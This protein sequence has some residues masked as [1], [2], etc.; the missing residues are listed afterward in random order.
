MNTV[1]KLKEVDKPFKEDVKKLLI[2]TS[3]L[4]F[5]AVQI[6]AF[7][8]DGTVFLKSSTNGGTMEKIQMLEITKLRLFETWD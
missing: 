5:V 8:E 7:K 3:E 6:I 1:T 2:E 4:G